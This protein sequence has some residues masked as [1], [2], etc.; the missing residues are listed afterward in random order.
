MSSD[1]E[2]TTDTG[3]TSES[4]SA[5]RTVIGRVVSNKMDKSVSVAIERVVKHPAYGKIV[6][7]TTKVIAHD[8][9]NA[10]NAGDTV[11]IVE[12]RP[13]SK[14]KAWRVVEILA[15]ADAQ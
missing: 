9:D 5:T 1:N 15:S 3:T 13:L 6:R 11:A 14:H 7:R 12:C 2:T 10:C 8:E 4:A